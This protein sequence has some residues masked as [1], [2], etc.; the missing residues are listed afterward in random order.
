MM[1]NY[2]KT[3]PTVGRKKYFDDHINLV[4]KIFID[5]PYFTYSILSRLDN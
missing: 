5:N 4:H 1:G 2:K 3:F